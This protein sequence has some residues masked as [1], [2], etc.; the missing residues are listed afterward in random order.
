MREFGEILEKATIQGIA[1]YL[2]YGVPPEREKRDYQSRLEES[3]LEYEKLA[4][5]Y[6]SNGASELLSLANA[7]ICDN[8]CVY[9]ELGLQ[10]GILFVIDMI[11]NM[12]REQT[13][14]NTECETERKA[15]E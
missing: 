7:M 5:Q 1:D 2:L 15:E 10:A 4:L 14:R 12:R 8:A 6:D 11:Q 13:D 9:M 3:Y